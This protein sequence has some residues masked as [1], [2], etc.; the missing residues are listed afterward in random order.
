VGD[1]DDAVAEIQRLR[2]VVGVTEIIF[3]ATWPGLDHKQ[4]LKMLDLL[5]TDVFPRVTQQ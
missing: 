4:R 5:R 2:E 3:T 1:P